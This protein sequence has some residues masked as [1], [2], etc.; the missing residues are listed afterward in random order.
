V[1]TD[2]I[3]SM[4]QIQ[5]QFEQLA[6]GRP[7]PSTSTQSGDLFASLITALAAQ[8]KAAAQS[9]GATGSSIVQA[10]AKYEGVPYVLG[11]TSTSGIDCSG[12]VQRS[13]AD[14]GIKVGRLVSDQKSAGT[15]VPSLAQARP[16]DLIVLDGGE[17]IVIYAGDGNVI[18]APYAGRTVTLQKAWFTQADVVTIR[19]VAPDASATQAMGTTA[20][21]AATAVAQSSAE[22]LQALIAAQTSMLT[23]SLA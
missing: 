22:A 19:R 9:A 18:H 12:L 1:I 4:K 7:R 11:G 13:L 6:T 2:S 3:A 20:A 5:T 17:H 15:E 16:G 23:G 10:A 21:S 8:D 14:V